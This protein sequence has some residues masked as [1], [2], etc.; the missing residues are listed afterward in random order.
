MPGPAAIARGLAGLSHGTE[1][2]D[3]T[4]TRMDLETDGLPETFEALGMPTEARTA[5][6]LIGQ[7]ATVV[8]QVLPFL[9]T[10]LFDRAA[11]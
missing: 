9:L 11:A 3:G 1:A 10:T 6:G 8:C 2:T 7:D 4:L 5:A